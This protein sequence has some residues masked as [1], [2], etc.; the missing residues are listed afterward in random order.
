MNATELYTRVNAGEMITHTGEDGLDRSLWLSAGEFVMVA[1][2]QVGSYKHRLYARATDADRLAAHWQGYSGMQCTGPAPATFAK[3]AKAAKAEAQA[4]KAVEA[5]DFPRRTW[6]SAREVEVIAT[7]GVERLSNYP[8]MMPVSDLNGRTLETAVYHAL[9]AHPNAV[10]VYIDGG[11]DA[12]ENFYEC[13]HRDEGFD[14]EPCVIVW[15]YKV[16]AALVE[17]MRAKVTG[18]QS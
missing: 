12:W 3:A 14:Y 2:G 7:D 10:E 6:L 5:K 11:F 4:V 18:G 13:M 9:K 1:Q 16:P 15:S 17:A 8:T